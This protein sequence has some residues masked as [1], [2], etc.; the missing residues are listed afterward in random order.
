VLE[1]KARAHEQLGE[2]DLAEELADEAE[3]LRSEAEERLMER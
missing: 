2:D 1:E 3:E